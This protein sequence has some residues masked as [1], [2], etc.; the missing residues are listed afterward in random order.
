MEKPTDPGH[1]T[2]RQTEP[3]P[4]S[5]RSNDRSEKTMGTVTTNVKITISKKCLEKT[6]IMKKYIESRFN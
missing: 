2:A 4:Q 3:T 5:D 1:Q 6:R